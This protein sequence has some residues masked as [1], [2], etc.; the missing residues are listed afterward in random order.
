MSTRRRL[1]R[2]GKFDLGDQLGFEPYTVV[3]SSVA[4]TY[5]VRFSRGDLRIVKP[6]SVVGAESVSFGGGRSKKLA[7]RATF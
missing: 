1:A 3:I 6:G 2:F 4:K 7:F 5:C